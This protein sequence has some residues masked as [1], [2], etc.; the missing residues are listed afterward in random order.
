LSRLDRLT[1]A[2]FS[3]VAQRRA[4]LGMKAGADGI[5][6]QLEAEIEGR[7]GAQRAI[8]FWRKA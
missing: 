6:S 2:E 3:R 8:G 7:K 4:I 5:V 1:P